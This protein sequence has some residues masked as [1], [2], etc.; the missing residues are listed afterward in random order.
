MSPKKNASDQQKSPSQSETG[1]A[2]NIANFQALIAVIKT[3]AKYKPNSERYTIAGLEATYQTALEGHDQ[4][5]QIDTA[6]GNLI[7]ERQDIF[8]PLTQLTTRVINALADT[9]ASDGFKKNAN[10]I[11][12]KIH[13]KRAKPIKKIDNPTGDTGI[14]SPSPK[15]IS[16]SQQSYDSMVEHFKELVELISTE[17]TYKNADAEISLTALKA[18]KIKLETINKKVKDAEAAFGDQLRT[19]NELLYHDK[20][21]LVSI[22]SDAKKIV[23]SAYG[24]RSPESKAVSAIKFKR[25]PK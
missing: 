11:N 4:L 10:A 9:E 25:I 5:T 16:V 3:L 15:T 24:F 19:R 20:S 12:R 8:D 6:W 1:H 21:G 7:G 17:P 18:L 14:E 22:A 13:G 2:K 23:R